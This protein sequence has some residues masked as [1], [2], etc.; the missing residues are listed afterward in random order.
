V[1]ARDPNDGSIVIL[2]SGRTAS[3]KDGHWQP[4]VLFRNDRLLEDFRDVSD[5]NEV[6][7]LMQQAA[8]ALQKS[9]EK[10]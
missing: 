7:A 1:I 8:E 10:K 2:D 9:S 4:G 3:F 6:A 5:P